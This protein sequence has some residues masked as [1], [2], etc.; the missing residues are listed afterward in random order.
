MTASGDTR[1]AAPDDLHVLEKKIRLHGVLTARTGMHVGSGE[2]TDLIDN[3]VLRDADGY[4]FIPGASLKGV[5]RSTMEAMLRAID[6]QELGLWACDP[7]DEENACGQYDDQHEY[8]SRDDVDV[9]G[10]CPVCRLLGSHL[11]SSHVRFSDLIMLDRE[12]PP[13]ISLRDG[14]AI[15][16][17]LKVVHGS[18]K[19]DF[20]VVD[21]GTRF[22]LE[23][24][25]DNP[26]DWSMGLLM[27]SFELLGQGFVGL[28]G[29]TSRGL[30]RVEIRWEGVEEFD[31]KALLAGKGPRPVRGDELE[32]LFETWRAALAAKAGGDA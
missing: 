29:L 10:H 18:L 6:D 14:V 2:A 24:F 7:L 12:G 31:A 28:G 4:P 11:V 15:D 32:A 5:V 19:Y 16:R 20:E 23:I 8:Q 9:S 17:D 30:G 26:E 1:R 27:A 22:D 3:A 13:P 25:V 21:P